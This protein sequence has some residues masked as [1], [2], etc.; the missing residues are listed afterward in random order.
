MHEAIDD[1][2]RRATGATALREAGVLQQLWSGY[3]NIVRY[4]LEGAETPSVIVK[5]VAFAGQSDH[6]RGWNTDIGHQRKL[7]SYEVEAAWY[8]DWAAR[9]GEFCR[10]PHCLAIETSGDELY[11]VLEDLDASGWSGRRRSVTRRELHACLHWLAAFHANFL[12][13]QPQ[14][15]W[16]TGTYWH[17][18]TRPDEL[19]ALDDGRLRDAAGIIDRLL[20]SSPYQTL[21][22]GDAKVANFCF[23]E[24]GGASVAAV[25]FQYVGGGCGMKDVAYF[26]GSVLRDDECEAHSAELLDTYFGFLRHALSATLSRAELDRLEGDWRRL[27]PVAWT[28]F[29]R[30]LKGWNPGHWKLNS[31]S[32]RLAREVVADI[33][34]GRLGLD[35]AST[36]AS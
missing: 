25:D 15:L 5:H 1:L 26:L 18:A 8:R 9:C 17:L 19:E 35:A 13:Q 23:R 3:G 31:Y 2:V 7:R 6:P 34:Q 12:G 14:G 36:G 32:E 21:V 4:R 28:D 33:A 16:E 24:D 11:L 10:V 30:F 22:H 20:S 27:Y 29:H